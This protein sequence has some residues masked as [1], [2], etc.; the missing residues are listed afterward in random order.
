MPEF[1]IKGSIF[2]GS[3]LS[4]VWPQPYKAG[5]M[6]WN[7][8]AIYNLDSAD[9]LD[10]YFKKL[11]PYVMKKHNG[12]SF[13]ASIPTFMS[14][15]TTNRIFPRPEKS[16][17]IFSTQTWFR[18]TG[19][20]T[21]RPSKLLPSFPMPFWFMEVP[22]RTMY[23][24]NNW[25]CF[26]GCHHGETI[27]STGASHHENFFGLIGTIRLQYYCSIQ[28]AASMLLFLVIGHFLVHLL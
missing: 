8:N 6:H 16:F 21:G 1:W 15:S 20:R 26:L 13:N 3:D 2:R 19:V 27:R 5:M 11:R 17:T 23:N 24:R 7:G 14:I 9:F 18:I 10:F 4:Q 22:T 25:S 12:D 28:Q